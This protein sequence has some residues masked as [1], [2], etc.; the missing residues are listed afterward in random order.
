VA[1]KVACDVKYTNEEID[2]YQK[3]SAI[4]EVIANPS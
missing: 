3:Y 2:N 1:I 4:K